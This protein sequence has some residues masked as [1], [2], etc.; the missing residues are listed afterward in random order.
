MIFSIDEDDDNG[1]IAFVIATSDTPNATTSM[2]VYRTDVTNGTAE[3]RV[4]TGLVPDSDVVDWT[5]YTPA[6]NC[7]YEYR[8]RAYSALGG[9]A[10]VTAT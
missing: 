1:L 6:S 10:D 4:A 3:I 2:D 7:L 5:D 9:F 8:I